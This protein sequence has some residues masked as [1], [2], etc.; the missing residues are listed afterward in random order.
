MSNKLKEVLLALDK[1]E[2]SNWTKD[3]LPLLDVV[4]KAFGSSVSRLMINEA[5]PGFNREYVDS[6]EDAE[7]IAEEQASVEKTEEPLN[8]EEDRKKAAVS[9]LE[10][11]K[12]ELLKAKKRVDEANDAVDSFLVKEAQEGT[13]NLADDV[14]AY[15]KA[16]LDMRKKAFA[17][18]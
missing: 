4:T 12:K 2:E 10:E 8:S 17:G 13:R 3:G 6:P 15:Q 14:S 1:S 9:E 11:A 5:L 16:Q 18:K 7:E